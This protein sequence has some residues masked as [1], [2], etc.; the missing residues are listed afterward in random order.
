[1]GAGITRER[2]RGV[3]AHA[4]VPAAAAQVGRC[5]CALY[6]EQRRSSRPGIVGR[7]RG[8]KFAV[9]GLA[10]VLA[11][12]LTSTPIRVNCINPVRARTLMRPAGV[13]PRTEARCPILPPS[14]APTSFFWVPP[15]AV[16]PGRLS[17]AS[18]AT[19]YCG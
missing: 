7:L 17:T 16:S 11:D 12:E 4:S 1:M 9:E 19:R 6:F 5:Q 8:L 18:D 2:H 3:R 13:P 10:Q 15:V 14:S